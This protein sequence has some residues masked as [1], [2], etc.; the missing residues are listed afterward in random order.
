MLF[1][2]CVLPFSNPNYNL[3]LGLSFIFKNQCIKVFQHEYDMF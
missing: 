3:N 2:L 1:Y